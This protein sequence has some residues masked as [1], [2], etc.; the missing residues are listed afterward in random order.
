MRLNTQPSEPSDRTKPCDSIPESTIAAKLTKGLCRHLLDPAAHPFDICDQHNLTLPELRAILDSEHVRAIADHIAAISAAR[1]SLNAP[2]ARFTA[3]RQLTELAESPHHQSPLEVRAAETTRRAAAALERATR[4]S[5]RL[6]RIP[7]DQS[8]VPSQKSTGPGTSPTP[9]PPKQHG[10][11][12][13]TAMQ[14]ANPHGQP[15]WNAVR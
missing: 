6:P 9:P 3:I 13:M 14:S 1:E 12:V 11:S 5:P 2:H 15:A 4:P 7:S 10:P 8:Q